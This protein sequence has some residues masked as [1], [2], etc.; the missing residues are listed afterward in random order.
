MSGTINLSDLD[1]SGLHAVVAIYITTII[2]IDP[3]TLLTG[4]EGGTYVPNYMCP[5][6]NSYLCWLTEFLQSVSASTIGVLHLTVSP[7]VTA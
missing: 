3:S 5:P 1:T 2:H 4:Q 6:Q 7:L